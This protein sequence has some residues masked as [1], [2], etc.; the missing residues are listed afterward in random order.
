M[1]VTIYDE[2][3]LIAPAGNPLV[4][5]FSSDQTAQP[6]FSFVV[7]LYINGTLRLTQEVFRQFNTLGRIDVSEA[8]QSTL[9]SP[10]VV[11][12]TL[13]TFYDTAINE[14]YIIVYEKYGTTPTIQ[15]SDTST[16]LYGFNGALRH[17][18]W[19][20]FDYR[21]YNSLGSSSF[22]PVNFLTTFPRTKKY[23][24]G[25]DERIFLGIFCTDTNIYARARVYDIN[26]NLIDGDII[27]A[28]LNDFTVFDVS[29]STIV[30]NSTITQ[31]TFDSG[32]Y[33]TIETM[34]LGLM[35]PVF[36][37]T[38]EAFK[39]W[40]D[41]ECKRYET[42][43]LHWLNKFG[44]WD[45]FTFSLVSIDSTTVQSYGYQREKGVWDGTSY[46]YPLY[47]GEK[48][49]FAKTASD[50][51]TL[52]SDW[53]NQDVQQWL[54]RELLE[55]PSVYLEVNNGT[56]FEPVKVTNTNYQLKTRRRD[57]LIQ[58][59][60]TIERTYTYRSQLN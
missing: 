3:Q 55:S 7:E 28:A 17:Q 39:I 59:Q 6:N 22:L 8:V 51:L 44:V 12:G 48:V 27:S 30:A 10:L 31:S 54:V 40:I 41:T 47:Q 32:A 36:N 46:T 13:T 52:N 5:T 49:D 24:C 38:S 16:T 19:I 11:D 2:P 53:I 33:Y 37:V 45:S 29:P 57:G 56:D 9:T 60:I 42:R 58:E 35:P 18:D 21:E 43:R 25:L 1:A 15:A 26:N 14:Y 50:Q 4:F 23:F 20:N 34:E